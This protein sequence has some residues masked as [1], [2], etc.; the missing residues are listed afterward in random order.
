MKKSFKVLVAGILAVTFFTGVSVAGRFGGGFGG[1]GFGGG[2]AH[3]GGGMGGAHFGGGNL[4]GGMHFGGGGLGGGVSHFGG[5]MGHLGGGG[6][7][8]GVGRPGGFGDFH[9]ST[10][11]FHPTS[12][13]GGAGGI[14]PGGINAGGIGHPYG[15]FGAATRPFG[16]NRTDINV[17][18]TINNTSINRVGVGA[19]PGLGYGGAGIYRGGVGYDRFG[20][21]SRAALGNA[22]YRPNYY[23]GWY[24][25]N[26]HN[27]WDRPWYGRPIGWG[28]GY[29]GAYMAGAM[30]TAPWNWG[31]WGYSN[32]YYSYSSGPAYLDYSQPVVS[33]DTSGAD[34]DNTGDTPAQSVVAGQ[35]D[36]PG[37]AVDQASPKDEAMQLFDTARVAFRSGDYAAALTQ[38]EQALEK[39]PKDSVLQEFRALV[40]FA[41]QDYKGAAAPLYAVLSA[42]PGWDWTTLIHLYANIDVYTDQIRTLEEYRKAHPDSAEA[43]FVLAYHYLTQGHGEAAAKELTKVVELNPRDTLSAQI[44]KSLTPPA[45]GATDDTPPTPDSEVKPADS[46]VK[47]GDTKPAKPL[48]LA[49]LVGNWTAS[50]DDGSAFALS[51]TKDNKFKWK[52][53]LNKKTQEYSGPYEVADNILIL[54]QNDSP[55]MVFEV[56]PMGANS[57]NF[58]L[59]GGDPADPGLVFGK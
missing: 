18:R 41:Q 38:V 32:P 8:G 7:G 27:N 22:Y 42:G 3:F 15:G 19:R 33:A 55:A 39:L 4:G 44:L 58:K 57:M 40:L 46:D 48:D 37:V 26:W 14:R 1:G 43:R 34:A 36:I 51:L 56:T 47:P 53:T 21:G 52:F 45:A 5:E 29:G 6:F 35:N 17:N 30:L 50:R 23:G 16:G 20:V 49:K 10:V 9:P 13:F 25:G 24:H 12:A 28:Y 2:G 54:K 59:A 11:G 31:Y